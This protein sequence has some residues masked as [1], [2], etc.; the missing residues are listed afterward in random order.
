MAYQENT[1][2]K[3]ND[4]AQQEISTTSKPRMLIYYSPEENKENPV[5]LTQ[6]AKNINPLT[7][8]PYITHLEICTLH[9]C[10]FDDGNYI[11]LNNESP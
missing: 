4:T 8:K 9:L 10:K 6:I 11:H 2:E 5:T 1:D 7:K 3:K